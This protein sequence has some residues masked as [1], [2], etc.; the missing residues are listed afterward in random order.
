MVSTR[1][2]RVSAQH[3]MPSGALGS[4]ALHWRGLDNAMQ[5]AG[6]LSFPKTSQDAPCRIQ[7]LSIVHSA[8]QEHQ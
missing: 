2:L 8:L 7:S 4:D 3:K 1:H 6:W 5:C